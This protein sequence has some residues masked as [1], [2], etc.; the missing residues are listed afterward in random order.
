M[1][2]IKTSLTYLPQYMAFPNQLTFFECK[3]SP[4]YLNVYFSR[5][6]FSPSVAGAAE[7]PLTLTLRA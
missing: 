5:E 2:K 3:R 6:R 4:F 7:K 1:I